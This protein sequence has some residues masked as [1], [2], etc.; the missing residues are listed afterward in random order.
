[1]PVY[2]I[3]RLQRDVD[4]QVVCIGQTTRLRERLREHFRDELRQWKE[5]GQR[6]MLFLRWT[7]VMILETH[8]KRREAL[9]AE[10]SQQRQAVK[11][12]WILARDRLASEPSHMG[13]TYDGTGRRPRK[14][15]MQEVWRAGAVLHFEA[16][17]DLLADKRAL[18]DARRGEVV[19]A[20]MEQPEASDRMVAQSTKV[21]RATVAYVR[22]RM[23]GKH[24]P[25]AATYVP[26]CN[27]EVDAEVARSA[28]RRKALERASDPLQAVEPSESLGSSEDF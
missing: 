26:L 22:E 15:Q 16:L 14:R 24:E 9:A 5:S 8:C 6:E 10:R 4:S 28:E 23:A 3:Y 19:E 20:I 25:T 2:M 18:T 21:S 7:E 27:P 11:A 17:A 13:R 1:M 12:G